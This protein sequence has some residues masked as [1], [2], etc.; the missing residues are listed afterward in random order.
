M[1]KS[2]ILGV[3]AGW[4]EQGGIEWHGFDLD[5]DHRSFAR[6]FPENVALAP[7]GDEPEG[8]LIKLLRGCAGLPVIVIDPRA[9]LREI[10]IR[11]F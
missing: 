9:H 5:P 7:L 8:D 4:L 10:L 3:I 2:T 6:L 11:G 1:G